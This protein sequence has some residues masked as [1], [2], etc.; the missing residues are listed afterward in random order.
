M[1][2]Q[3]TLLC[4]ATVNGVSIK[5]GT[6]LDGDNLQGIVSSKDLQTQLS[7]KLAHQII[8]RYTGKQIE[9]AKVQGVVIYVFPKTFEIIWCDENGKYWQYMDKTPEPLIN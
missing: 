6:V 5:Y 7:R 9:L 3:S 8:E 2:N 1:L 4:D